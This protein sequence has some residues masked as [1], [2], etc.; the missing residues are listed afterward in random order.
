M[1]ARRECALAKVATLTTTRQQLLAYLIHIDIL[2]EKKDPTH[3]CE[4]LPL[5]SNVWGAVSLAIADALRRRTADVA[6]EVLT[7][8]HPARVGRLTPCGRVSAAADVNLVGLATD[9]A[10]AVRRLIIQPLYLVFLY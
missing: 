4:V 8:C 10:L 6:D 3:L 7:T 2:S 5:A 9:V 1:Y